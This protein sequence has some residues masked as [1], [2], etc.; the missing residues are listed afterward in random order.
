[1]AATPP[2]G[3]L[4]ACAKIIFAAEGRRVR[5]PRKATAEWKIHATK[6]RFPGYLLRL[7]QGRSRW[8]IRTRVP[9]SK[10]RTPDRSRASSKAAAR[11]QD[12]SSRTRTVRA[13]IRDSRA[14]SNP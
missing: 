13:K 14:A 12:S 9:V 4:K 1:M 11:S 3:G 8:L 7:K 2:E 6:A 10:I 5:E